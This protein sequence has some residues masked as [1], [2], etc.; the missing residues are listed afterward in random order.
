MEDVQC[1]YAKNCKT[2]LRKNKENLHKVSIIPFSS[3]GILG[4]V[5]KAIFSKLIC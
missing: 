4:R 2:M 3:T 5:K 1:M